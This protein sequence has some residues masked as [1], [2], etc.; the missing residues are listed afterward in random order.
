MF[1]ISEKIVFQKAIFNFLK[2]RLNTADAFAAAC[3]MDSWIFELAS[4]SENASPGMGTLA[5]CDSFFERLKNDPDEWLPK[6]EQK[7]KSSNH[8]EEEKV[9]AT[10]VNSAHKRN[11]ATVSKN[12]QPEASIRELQSMIVGSPDSPQPNSSK[13]ARTEAST[14]EYSNMQERNHVLPPSGNSQN[15]STAFESTK[16]SRRRV[17]VLARSRLRKGKRSRSI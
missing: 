17:Y 13:R 11:H 7:Q 16:K 12:E 8:S 1:I 3:D 14:M 10:T 5:A 4:L 2:V 9:E 6:D 15:T